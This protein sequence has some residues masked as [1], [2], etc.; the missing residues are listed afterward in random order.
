MLGI[1]CLISTPPTLAFVGSVVPHSLC[2]VTNPKLINARI[3]ENESIDADEP[4][5]YMRRKALKKGSVA[6][7]KKEVRMKARPHGR[8]STHQR[9]VNLDASEAMRSCC[10]CS[11]SAPLCSDP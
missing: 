7:I 6:V 5:G 9:A 2:I 10:R 1:T 11:G 8:T 3:D 4:L